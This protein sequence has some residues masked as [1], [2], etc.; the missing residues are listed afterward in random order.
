MW[1]P[2]WL[3]ASATQVRQH[4]RMAFLNADAV[5]AVLEADVPAHLGTVDTAGFPH[6]TPVW[7]LW[8][9]GAFYLSSLAHRPHV[10]RLRADPRAFVVVDLEEHQAVEGVRPNWQVK[11]LGMAEVQVDVGNGWTAHISQK[12]LPGP[13]AQPV[14][15]G[16]AHQERVV[17]RLEPRE[18]V[19]VGTH[20]D[21]PPPTRET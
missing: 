8:S 16:R 20:P 19:A 15:E 12:Y 6:V 5:R 10:A 21:R 3:L 14:R 13:D 9:D 18:L 7:F 11:G 2:G 1:G 17:I 4:G